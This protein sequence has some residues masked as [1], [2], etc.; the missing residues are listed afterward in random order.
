M[1]WLFRETYWSIWEICTVI[2]Q[3]SKVYPPLFLCHKE[4]TFLKYPRKFVHFSWIRTW[5]KDRVDSFSRVA[6]RSTRLALRYLSPNYFE[7]GSRL[8]SIK[9]WSESEP[10]VEGR[11][12]SMKVIT[13]SAHE[14]PLGTQLNSSPKVPRGWQESPRPHRPNPRPHRPLARFSA[15]C[16]MKEFRGGRHG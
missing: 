16:A 14:D 6:K 9:H 13:W 15:T 1:I 8:V 5:S 12:L 3:K 11:C 7:C 2:V 10:G 4:S